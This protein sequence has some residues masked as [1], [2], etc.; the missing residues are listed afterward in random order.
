MRSARTMGIVT[1]CNDHSSRRMLLCQYL[2]SNV[3]IG[4]MRLPLETLL[5]NARTFSVHKSPQ[6]GSQQLAELHIHAGVC[7]SKPVERYIYTCPLLAAHF[8]HCH[9]LRCHVGALQLCKGRIDGCHMP[10]CISKRTRGHEA[11]THHEM[12]SVA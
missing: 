9:G 7:M 12:Q 5:R 2:L 4:C 6:T 1:A 11:S 8:L 3:W 10:G